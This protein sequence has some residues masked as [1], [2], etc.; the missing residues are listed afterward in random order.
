MAAESIL[1]YKKPG[2]PKI[3]KTERGDQTVIEYVGPQSTLEA[4]EPAM[5]AAWG[6]YDGIVKSTASH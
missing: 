6:D 2:F 4:A 1:T 5:N 3:S